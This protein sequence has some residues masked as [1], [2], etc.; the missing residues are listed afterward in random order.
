MKAILLIVLLATGLATESFLS[1]S[2][3]IKE[4]ELSE[5]HF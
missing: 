4:M 3:E 2:Q 5:S 1:T